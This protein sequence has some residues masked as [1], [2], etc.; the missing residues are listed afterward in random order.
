[1]WEIEEDQQMTEIWA[2]EEDATWPR[3]E[4]FPLADPEGGFHK[5]PGGGGLEVLTSP[6]CILCSF[7]I[8]NNDEVIL[9]VSYRYFI[10]SMDSII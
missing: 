1:M 9:S 7:C 6:L 10:L 3:L 2:T 8:S 5:F 4:M